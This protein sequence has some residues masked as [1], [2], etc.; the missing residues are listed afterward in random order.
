[1]NPVVVSGKNLRIEDVVQVAR[2]NAGVELAPEAL[3]RIRRCRA[4]LEKKLEARE[5]MYG[6]NTGIGE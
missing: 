1:M 5:V 2:E 6:T 3:E 4:M